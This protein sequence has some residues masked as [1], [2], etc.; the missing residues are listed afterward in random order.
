MTSNYDCKSQLHYSVKDMFIII[1]VFKNIYFD[2][3]P[4]K[5]TTHGSDEGISHQTDP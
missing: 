5:Q 2:F 1:N 4:I 3:A